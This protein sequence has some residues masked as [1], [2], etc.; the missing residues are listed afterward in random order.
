MRI[1]SCC[2]TQYQVTVAPTKAERDKAAESGT[3]LA[4]RTAVRYRAFYRVYVPGE[5]VREVKVRGF[6]RK[7]EAESFLEHARWG[8]IG[9][10]G[11]SLDA[12]L[13]PVHAGLSTAA[14]GAPG[15]SCLRLCEEYWAVTWDGKGPSQRSKVR[16]RLLTFAA[17]TLRDPAARERLLVALEVQRPGRCR[18]EPADAVE[19]VARWMRDELFDRPGAPRASATGAGDV[20]LTNDGGAGAA[21]M[22]DAACRAWLE[23]RSLHRD[24]LD[25]VLL[26]EVRRLLGGSKSATLRTYWT[27][28]SAM[29][30]WA[31]ASGRLARDPSAGMPKPGRDLEG[32]RCDP[33]TTPGEVEILALASAAGAR[34]GQWAFVFV[35]VVAF[36]ALR[37]GEAVQLRRRD[38]TFTPDGGAW[39]TVA[40]QDG[41]QSARHSADGT[42]T[43]RTG[44]PT[45]GRRSVQAARRR[46][47]LSSR[48]A[49]YLQS[50]LDEKVGREPDARLFTGKR[51]G[52]LDPSYF[53][54]HYW[55]LLVGEVFPSGHRLHEIGPHALRHAGMSLWLRAQV[56][57]KMIQQM[58]GW[59][60]LRV[61]LDTYAAVLPDDDDRVVA[62]LEPSAA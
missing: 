16:G 41:R 24:A 1:G 21:D 14:P 57:L 54:D 19:R 18:P 52:W 48:W 47:Y 43:R 34:L 51:G 2:V 61:M 35:L 3:P 12:R 50:H 40:T 39:V 27:V 49:G 26:G 55:A 46:I 37:I 59:A 6:R 9:H 58:G 23:R 42:S 25:D 28:V 17:A 31:A 32:E 7:G 11:W 30:S 56:P 33:E 38:V 15:E 20:A 62:A 53:R 13:H 45:K 36:C 60:S 22:D 5:K 4:K 8:A 29:L 44:T 10:G